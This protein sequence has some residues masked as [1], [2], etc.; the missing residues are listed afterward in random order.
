MID[1]SQATGLDDFKKANSEFIANV[2]AT[3]PRNGETI[4]IPGEQAASEKSAKLSED[5]IELPDELWKE[6]K[7]L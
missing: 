3:R 7:S 4:R 2:K 1:P 6:I 5:T